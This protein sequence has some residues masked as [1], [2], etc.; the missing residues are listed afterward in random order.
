MTAYGWN[1]DG[2]EGYEYS[3]AKPTISYNALMSVLGAG[4]HTVT[5]MVT[6]SNGGVATATT[7]INVVAPT[8]RMYNNTSKT[9]SYYATLQSAYNVAGNNSV[10]DL[11]TDATA[12]GL[13]LAD[14]NITVTLNG[15]DTG[16]TAATGFTSIPAPLTLR[17][18]KVIMRNIKVQPA[19]LVSI[20]VTPANPNIAVAASQQMTATGT[21][22]DLSTV[23]LTSSVTWSSADPTKAS[24][25]S[26]GGLV[27]GV[28]VGTSNIT[29][30][31]GLITGN[32]TVTVVPAP[33]V[34]IAVTPANPTITYA[35]AQQMTATGTYADASIADLTSLVTWN[36][37]TPANVTVSGT[38]LALGVI[39][40]GSSDISAA[41][42]T[43]I[44]K[45]TVTV[46][47]AALV[48]IAVTPATPTIAK[49]L[50]QQMTATGTYADASTAVLTGSVTWASLDQ[51]TAA[52]S[53][54]GLVTS[55]SEGTSSITAT[56]G[57]VGSTT[58]TVGP[59]ALVSI[60][61]TPAN[62]TLATM[63]SNQQM[64]ATGT[65]TDASVADLTASV[66]WNSADPS[67]AFITPGPS[68]GSLTGV[69]TGGPISI[70]AT[71][72]SVVG[73]TNV[74]VP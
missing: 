2:K 41:L 44:G 42:G 59:A 21:N 9:Y 48:S 57:V 33:L 14:R 15:M 28:A 16:F 51:I 22:S 18:G 36:S 29:A 71:S 68:G 19:G 10:I 65:Y 40:N 47:P 74:N 66:T 1:L 30:T 69:A 26:S 4:H 17:Q 63:T 12:P 35:G 32:T 24:V 3:V 70:T 50:S 73:T 72:G 13:L 52:V 37:A 7:D 5:F 61:V 27:T 67:I 60:E 54:G 38:G 49:G 11:T 39:A 53:A 20:A 43:I 46:G 58:V 31:L 34:S 55:V 62:S 6:D 25:I 56:L 45:T 8:V 23:D 64:T